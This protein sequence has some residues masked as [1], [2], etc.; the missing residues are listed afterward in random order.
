[1]VQKMNY[2]DKIIQNTWSEIDMI[3]KVKGN[4]RDK[5]YHDN[6]QYTLANF[7]EREKKSPKVAWLGYLKSRKV[8]G[9]SELREWL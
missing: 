5:C 2:F 9:L 3:N 1:M 4:Y 8:L 6:Y 7:F